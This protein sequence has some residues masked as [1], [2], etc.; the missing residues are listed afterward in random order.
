M[1]ISVYLHNEYYQ[2]L[3][4]FG[5]IDEVVN[6]ILDYCYNNEIDITTIANAPS[7]D[8]A[9]RVTIGV[10]H[11]LYLDDYSTCSPNSTKYSLRKIIYWFI[12][13][14]IYEELEW[15]VVNNPETERLDFIIKHLVIILDEIGKLQFKIDTQ[16]IEMLR[17]ARQIIKS[18]EARYVN[19]YNE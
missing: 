10:T 8:G 14:A 18:L 7:R 2:V 19:E 15:K 16:D 5:N 4:A 12:D 11:Q 6:K 17:E 9:R 3:K 1:L 13:N